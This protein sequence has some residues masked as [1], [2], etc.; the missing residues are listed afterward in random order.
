MPGRYYLTESLATLAE[1]LEASSQLVD[2]GP[3]PDAAP[4]EIAVVLVDQPRRLIEM[5]WNMIMSG[6]VNARGR[7]VMETITNARSETLFEKSAFEGVRR[8]VLPVSGWYEWTGKKGR[9]SRWRMSPVNAERFLFAAIW[10]VWAA[11]GGLEVLQMAT[12]TVEPNA[13]VA[14]YHHRMPA[15]LNPENLYDWFS[16]GVD[17]AKALLSPAEPGT[18][19]VQ[20]A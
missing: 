14:E 18:V 15:I 6:R 11:P 1:A 4:G 10:D 2:P 7:P 19:L 12:V 5:R 8:A 16:G 20:S 13:D 17:Q 9:K 3:R